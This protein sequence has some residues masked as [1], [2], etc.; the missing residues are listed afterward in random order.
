MKRFI[1]SPWYLILTYIS[2]VFAFA[3]IYNKFFSDQFYHQTI[4]YEKVFA[5]LKSNILLDLKDGIIE[6]FENYH[7]S[8]HLELKKGYIPIYVDIEKI[9]LDDLT[10]ESDVLSFTGRFTY[11]DIYHSGP[12]RGQPII[13]RYIFFIPETPLNIKPNVEGE[14]REV[15]I[16]SNGDNPIK[17]EYVLPKKKGDLYSYIPLSRNSLDR[18]KTLYEYNRGIVKKNSFL[19]M[20]YFSAVTISTIGYGDIM[21]I[22]DTLRMIVS[23]EAILGIIFIGLFINALGNKYRFIQS[24]HSRS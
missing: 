5:D 15:G 16:Q 12:G 23:F 17:Q 4:K 20:L 8:K 21:P 24:D 14:T 3:G 2:L 9:K 11:S 10:I 18:I 7:G 1:L 13:Y 19:R 22:D 6:N